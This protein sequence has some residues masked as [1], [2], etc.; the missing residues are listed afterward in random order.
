LVAVPVLSSVMRPRSW[1]SSSM[2]LLNKPTTSGVSSGGAAAESTNVRPVC[3]VTRVAS[4]SNVSRSTRSSEISAC[5]LCTNRFNSLRSSCQ[6]ACAAAPQTPSDKS[7]TKKSTTT[8][9][10]QQILYFLHSQAASKAKQSRTEQNKTKQTEHIVHDGFVRRGGGRQCGGVKRPPRALRAPQLNNKRVGLEILQEGP[11]H[12][13]HGE[14]LAVQKLGIDRADHRL[15]RASLGVCRRKEERAKERRERKEKEEREGGKRRRKGL[16]SLLEIICLRHFLEGYPLF[17]SFLLLLLL[18]PFI[19]LSF[20]FL[21][22][23]PRTT[24]NEPV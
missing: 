20:I 13:L 22:S 2:K 15:G 4:F 23:F 3:S 9:N 6:S 19:A 8:T 24:N 17:P 11:R 12:A 5:R 7:T 10:E 18:P 16:A 21:L 14:L 1:R